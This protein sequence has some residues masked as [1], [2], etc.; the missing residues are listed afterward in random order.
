MLIIR[1]CAALALAVLLA[2]C[3]TSTPGLDLGAGCRST[4]ECA[5]GLTCTGGFCKVGAGGACDVVEKCAAPLLCEEG[6]CKVPGGLDCGGEKPCTRGYRC[7]DSLCRGDLSLPCAE[8][9][10]CRF[11]LT[12]SDDFCK[13]AAGGACSGANECALGTICDDTLCRVPVAGPCATSASCRTGTACVNGVCR[14]PRSGACTE[15]A[16][17]APDLL[18]RD[19]VCVVP[20]GGACT[21]TGDCALGLVCDDDLACRTPKLGDCTS[22]D[23]C[24]GAL[25]CSGGSCRVAVLGRCSEGDC[26]EGLTCVAGTCRA[27]PDGACPSGTEC[28]PGLAC[29]QGVCRGDQGSACSA[30]QCASGLVCES[31]TCVGQTGAGCDR[32]TQCAAAL[33]CDDGFCRR[34]VNGLCSG[35]AEC[36]T[37]LVCDAGACRVPG[38]GR[39]DGDV[40]VTG[41]VCQDGQ[42]VAPPSGGCSSA[43]PCGVGYVCSNGLCRRAPGQPCESAGECAAGLVCSGGQCAGALGGTCGSGSPCALGL[44]CSG[45][46]CRTG[47]TGACTNSDECASGLQCVSGVCKAPLGGPCTLASQ[48]PPSTL[49]LAGTCRGDAGAECTATTSECRPSFGCQAGRCRGNSGAPCTADASCATG[50]VCDRQTCLPAAPQQVP[51]RELSS[52]GPDYTVVS[53]SAEL[54]GYDGAGTT[55]DLVDG[56]SPLAVGDFNGDGVG[57]LAI[58]APAASPGSRAGAGKV[59]V[60]FG[61]RERPLNPAIVDLSPAAIDLTTP[62][63]VV[64]SG[65]AAGD[66]AGT[67]VAAADMNGDGIGDLAIGIP[68]HD[69]SGTNNAGQVLVLLGGPASGTKP[70]FPAADTTLDA[71]LMGVRYLGEPGARLGVNLARGDHDGDG[72]GDLLVS[73]WSYAGSSSGSCLYVSDCPGAAYVF[74]GAASAAL[75]APGMTFDLTQGAARALTV[76]GTGSAVGNALGTSTAMGDLDGDGKDE[77][78]VNC[79][80]CSA[81]VSGA[82]RYS[83]ALVMKGRSRGGGSTVTTG[84]D[85]SQFDLAWFGPSSSR[86]NDALAAG[87]VTGDGRAELFLAA[88]SSSSTRELYGLRGRA[89]L[90]TNPPVGARVFTAAA[91]DEFGG[92]VGFDWRATTLSSSSALGLR[93]V[94]ADSD[95]DGVGDLFVSEPTTGSTSGL[96]GRG[97]VWLLYGATPLLFGAQQTT[98]IASSPV[99]VIGWDNRKQ[100]GVSLAAGDVNADGHADL[101]GTAY[102][103]AASPGNAVGVLLGGTR[104]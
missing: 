44:V 57:D 8:A 93:M 63:P 51:T 79:E 18:C 68:G 62:R 87:D 40:C 16:D 50:L 86:D 102:A 29:D 61:K 27:G 56:A 77:A 33:V 4:D 104:P 99:R 84:G 41:L 81:T 23:D 26:G 66:A 88:Q 22:S 94:V 42:C 91:S 14:V 36:A 48:C 74:L 46:S 19:S 35:D 55:S 58:G 101:V 95:R 20:V 31:G 71:A 78:I 64:L 30:G 17:C 80:R 52:G 70:A 103:G 69:T 15:Q 90:F 28:G 5:A 65:A 73:A 1:P 45:G 72:V 75:F 76:K 11:G 83:A 7:E 24:A 59:Y 43:K 49:C 39:C 32:E 47:A 100:F 54:L 92:L 96:G 85:Y 34:D 2:G 25:V 38:F 98:P 10:P 13:V 6:I 97:T 53:P 12:C 21:V 3:P 82:S 60:V 9:L 37:G 89:D 67:S